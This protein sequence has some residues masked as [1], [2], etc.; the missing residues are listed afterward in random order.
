[1]RA[2]CSCFSE[3]EGINTSSLSSLCREDPEVWRDL[4]LPL[5]PDLDSVVHVMEKVRGDVDREKPAADQVAS[6]CIAIGT[7]KDSTVECHNI[8][9]F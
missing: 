8:W 3:L 5:E 6:A 7:A 4:V 9:E 2:T 1:M